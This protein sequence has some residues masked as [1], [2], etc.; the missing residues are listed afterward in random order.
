MDLPAF[1]SVD[2]PNRP[3]LVRHAYAKAGEMVTVKSTVTDSGAVAAGLPRSTILRQGSVLGQA[4][5]DSKFYNANDVTNVGNICTQGSVTSL[6]AIGAGAANKLFKFRVNGG[7]EITVTMGAGDNT[8][9][10]VVTKLLASIP[11]AA[12]LFAANVNTNFLQ[13]STLRA[14][15]V[16]FFEITT[17]NFNG[18]GGVGNDTFA[19][20]TKAGG[21]DGDYRV[22]GLGGGGF[23]DVLDLFGPL[24]AVQDKGAANLKSAEFKT[25]QLLNLTPEAKAVLTRRGSF[26][27]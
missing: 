11:F 22:L 23:D 20:N 16:E 4:V 15:A 10:L 3:F 24:G 17:G 27:G 1:N 25:T 18:Q 9:D 5:A 7:Q 8:C 14:G 13:I 12:N 2:I 6:I 26:F 21:S 19:D